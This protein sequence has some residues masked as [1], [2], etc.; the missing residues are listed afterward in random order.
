MRLVKI[1]ASISVVLFFLGF[2]FS[3]LWLQEN[4]ERLFLAITTGV[5]ASGAVW[6]S[7]FCLNMLWKAK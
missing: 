3:V 6:G 5:F 1:I 2:Y 4:N 7:I